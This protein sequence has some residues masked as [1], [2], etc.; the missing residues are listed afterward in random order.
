MWKEAGFD[1]VPIEP[2]VSYRLQADNLVDVSTGVLDLN[3]D[4]WLKMGGNFGKELKEKEN[5]ILSVLNSRSIHHGHPHREN[6]VLRFFRDRKGRVDFTREPRI[7][8][9]DFDLAK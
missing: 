7:Y 5:R 4:L 6:V 3:L 1:Y 2:I 8:L 9:I